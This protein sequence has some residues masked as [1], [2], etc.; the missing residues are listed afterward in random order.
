MYLHQTSRC[1]NSFSTF[2]I[3]THNAQITNGK[4]L[5]FL[6]AKKQKQKYNH[7]YLNRPLGRINNLFEGVD[8]AEPVHLH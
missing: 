6:F 1:V 3:H 7:I 5:T 2:Q 4:I 8:S